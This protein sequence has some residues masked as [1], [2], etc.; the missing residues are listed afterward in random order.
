ML[1]DEGQYGL[2]IKDE[3]ARLYDLKSEADERIPLKRAPNEEGDFDVK[4]GTKVRI[5]DEEVDFVDEDD[6]MAVIE[7]DEESERILEG[8]RAEF[9]EQLEYWDTTMVAEY[10]EEIFEYMADLEVSD[11][12]T[13]EYLSFSTILMVLLP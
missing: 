5:V 4:D 1:R 13:Y 7:E 11:V 8:L 10:S 3:E 2:G 6:W 12:T 9:D